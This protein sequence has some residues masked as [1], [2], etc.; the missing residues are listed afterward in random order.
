MGKY[1]K[2]FTNK[3]PLTYAVGEEIIFTVFAREDG[4]NIDCGGVRWS[5]DG[6]DGSSLSGKA[7]INKNNPLTVSYTLKRAG[8]VHL[9]VTAVDE[10]DEVNKDFEPLD[11]SAG[12]NICDIEYSDSLPDDFYDFW[13]RVKK[14][15]DEYP[16]KVVHYEEKTTNVPDGFMA[17][18]VMIETPFGRP[19]SGCV[20]MPIKE[21]KYPIEVSFL[22]YGVHAAGFHYKE[23]KICG[24]FNAHGF[25]NDKCDSELEKIYCPELSWYGFNDEQNASPENS[26]F[27]GMMIRNFIGLKYLKN[28]TCWNGR[29][30][31]SVGGSQGALQAITVAAQDSD[32]TEVVAFKPWLCDLKSIECGYLGGWR[33]NYAEGLRY[34]D[35]VAQGLNLKCPITLECY[36]GDYCCPPKTV[37]SLYNSIKS[38]KKIKF[39]QSARHSYFPPEDEVVEY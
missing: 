32:V 19:A 5:L 27:K 36:L 18:Y 20:A 13:A 9:Y 2:V 28:L 37:I 21:G 1:F 38:E 8:F 31:I 23:G 29:D 7:V 16:I 12:A 35:T 14:T 4:K 11:S 10:K 3:N 15:V 33:P 30:I 17:Y 6:D 25:E 39:I 34:Y 24:E 22:G 26:Y